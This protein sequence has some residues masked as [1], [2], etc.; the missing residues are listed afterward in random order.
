MKQI[1]YWTFL[2]ILIKE[3]SL[4]SNIRKCCRHDESLQNIEDLFCINSTLFIELN[5]LNSNS[6]GLPDCQ[7]EGKHFYLSVDKI[8]DDNLYTSSAA[9]LD[10]LYDNQTKNNLP[11]IVYCDQDAGDLHNSKNSLR[12]PQVLSIRKCCPIGQ[13]FDIEGKSCVSSKDEVNFK[14]FLHITNEVDLLAL[15][16]GPPVCE[17]TLVNYVIE[18]PNIYKYQGKVL[19]RVSYNNNM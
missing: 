11:I 12:T 9:C 13:Y 7:L 6:M 16:T 8:H 4:L 10:H 1:F 17:K 15:D 2:L 3:A 5:N 14:T 18:S 19:V